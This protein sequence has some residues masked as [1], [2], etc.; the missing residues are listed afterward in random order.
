MRFTDDLP[1]LT[2]AE[3]KRFM[4]LQAYERANRNKAAA[5]RLLGV[6]PKTV[7]ENL[8]RIETAGGMQ[9]N[10]GKITRDH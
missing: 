9:K 1:I 4:Y 6:N 5:A 10:Q 2:A 3:Q 7:F 8:R